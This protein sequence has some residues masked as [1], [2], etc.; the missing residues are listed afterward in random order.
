MKMELT[1]WTLHRPSSPRWVQAPRICSCVFYSTFHDIIKPDW[2]I[3]WYLNLSHAT[4]ASWTTS[5]CRCCSQSVSVYISGDTCKDQ[6]RVL[7]T[8]TECIVCW[9]CWSQWQFV[10]VSVF[11]L[12]TRDTRTQDIR[13]G[14]K[15][16]KITKFSILDKK[17][18]S[19]FWTKFGRKMA[20][21]SQK[22]LSNSF[23][24]IGIT[25]MLLQ[26]GWKNG[27]LEL[28]GCERINFLS[29]NER[30]HWTAGTTSWRQS[31]KAYQ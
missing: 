25:I 30:M 21:W 3:D 7:N 17:Q 13:F 14:Q 22:K 27:C 10:P 28:L 4:V 1:T 29:Q 9:W 6:Q 31:F 18:N 12:I 23:T 16:N 24:F 19:Q 15:K 8:A 11:H 20:N 2:L 5:C 26:L